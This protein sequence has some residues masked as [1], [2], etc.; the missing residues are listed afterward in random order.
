MTSAPSCSASR[1]AQLVSFPDLVSSFWLSGSHRITIVAAMSDDQ[2]PE[3]RNSLSPDE[4]SPPPFGGFTPG[5][6]LA[7]A[8]VL[9][10]VSALAGGLAGFLIGRSQA[11]EPEVIRVT[12]P[13]ASG[14]VTPD[15]PDAGN[16]DSSSSERIDPLNL[17]EPAEI[18][19]TLELTFTSFKPTKSSAETQSY[20]AVASL[21]NI[22]SRPLEYGG[23]SGNEGDAF[24]VDERGR[25][26]DVDEDYTSNFD[27]SCDSINPGM[28]TTKKVGFTLPK[29]ATP[30]LLFGNPAIA[31]IYGKEGQDV[32]WRVN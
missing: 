8:M 9:L 14:D 32:P 25:R 6:L 12:A 24:V 11:P 19:P 26:F 22:G 1:F 17:G 31:S 21:K 29:D 27:F 23:C 28:S 16:T 18:D 13:G 15:S 4:S 2:L 20:V 7:G 30:K 5:A 3:R 10:A